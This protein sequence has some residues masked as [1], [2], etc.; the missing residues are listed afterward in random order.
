MAPPCV[1]LLT[2]PT[3]WL[4]KTGRGD[5]PLEVRQQAAEEMDM[6]GRTVVPGMID[7]HIHVY[8]VGAA[9]AQVDLGDCAS[10][11]ALQD[12]GAK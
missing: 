7:A 1:V 12:K 4:F 3:N 10:L 5:P 6:E 8:M 2:A 9:N 11:Q